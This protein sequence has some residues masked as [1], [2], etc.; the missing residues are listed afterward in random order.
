M[1]SLMGALWCCIVTS[2]VIGH[3]LYFR[4]SQLSTD[5][6]LR[7]ARCMANPHVSDLVFQLHTRKTDMLYLFWHCK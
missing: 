2:G 5:S 4:P 6:N 3:K 7:Q 1:L